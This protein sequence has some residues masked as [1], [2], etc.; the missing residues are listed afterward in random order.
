M[1]TLWIFK[2]NTFYKQ[3]LLLYEHKM[4]HYRKRNFILQFTI[5]RKTTLRYFF[6]EMVTFV[7]LLLIA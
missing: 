6:K 4:Q 2:T 5:V 1:E 3:S 7:V